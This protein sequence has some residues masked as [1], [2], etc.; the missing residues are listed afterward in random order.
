MSIVQLGCPS[1]EVF[2]GARFRILEI[3]GENIFYS[4]LTIL[5]VKCRLECGKSVNREEAVAFQCT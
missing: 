3:V 4:L 2:M 5:F 1:T